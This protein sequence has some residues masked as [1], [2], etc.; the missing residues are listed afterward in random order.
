MKVKKLKLPKRAAKSGT[1]R[2]ARTPSPKL[3]SGWK[4][5]RISLRAFVV[6]WRLYAKILLL[7]AVPSDLLAMVGSLAS[8]T[9]FSDYSS[10][11]A[12]VMNVALLWAVIRR[13]EGG[14]ESTLAESYYDG[15]V[16]LIRYVLV[17]VLLVL[18]LVPLALGLAL[19]GA[20]LYVQGI[21]PFSA[22]EL[23]VGLVALLLASPTL[24]M[25]VRFGLAP[26]SVVRDGLRPF[27]ALHRSWRLTR[28]HFWAVAGRLVLLIVFLT[29]TS[30]PAT[31]VTVL[32]SALKAKIF[33]VALFEILETLIALPLF[34]LYT[35]ELY[36]QLEAA[37]PVPPADAA[38]ET[39]S[40]DKKPAE[41]AEPET[42][43]ESGERDAKEPKIAPVPNEKQSDAPAAV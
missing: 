6:D 4:L 25:L 37:A 21:N 15:N 29:V 24:V 7:V 39:D 18:M 26:I 3:N 41:A 28:K 1:P 43:G 10:M 34:D 14:L 13:R 12:I 36:R 38:A 5:Y 8:N 19:Y 22:V 30:I 11:A 42:E 31:V 2:P 32:L 35:L 17:S 27:A 16:A 33:A 9:F 20:S 40:G 23:L